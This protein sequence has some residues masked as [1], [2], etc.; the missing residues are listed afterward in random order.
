MFWVPTHH[1]IGQRT[2]V[3]IEAN[4]RHPSQMGN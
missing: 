1:T 4:E 3:R 2:T